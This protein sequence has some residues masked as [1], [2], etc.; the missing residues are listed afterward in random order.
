MQTSL[1]INGATH[2]IDADPRTTLLDVLRNH[3]GM[4]GSKKG[5]DHGQCGACTVIVNGRRINSCLALACMMDG[6]A[7]ATV[8]GL[9]NRLR[10][11]E[12]RDKVQASLDR[13]R[14]HG[15]DCAGTTLEDAAPQR[16]P[17]PRRV[18]P[19]SRSGSVPGCHPAA[20]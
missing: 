12:I 10:Q 18:P 8:E 5:C 17:L 1:N 15:A 20:G 11:S 7:I 9:G 2:R 4:T 19:S 16:W 3:L 14:S 6:K 13:W